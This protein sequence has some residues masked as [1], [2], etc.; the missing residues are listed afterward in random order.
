[1]PDRSLLCPAS[2]ADGS[3]Q[4]VDRT[5]STARSGPVGIVHVIREVDGSQGAIRA[6]K[7]TCTLNA[8]NNYQA[9]Q[10]RLSLHASAATL[11]AYRKEAER[12]ILWAVL[13]PSWA[14]SALTVEDAVAYRPFLRKPS[15]A[16]RWV[17]PAKPRTSPKW[18]PFGGPLFPKSVSYAVS[19]IGA[20]HH[21]LIE[22][23][24]LLANSLSA[25]KVHG[26]SKTRVMETN[27]VFI[28]GE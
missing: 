11:R 20:L 13:E 27:H 21:W 2:D 28:Q 19:V 9:V 8:D 26:A 12:L 23:G 1:M 17:G 6:P 4:G 10:A 22:K 5:S 3:R 24:Y 15:P 14:L 25:I 7:Q 18:R 16:N